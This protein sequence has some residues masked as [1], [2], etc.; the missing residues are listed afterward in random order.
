MKEPRQETKSWTLSSW[1]K[2]LKRWEKE[3]QCVTSPESLSI[4]TWTRYQGPPG[5]MG[6]G[7]GGSLPIVE[8]TEFQTLR[9]L[10][11]GEAEAHHL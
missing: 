2:I 3:R 7:E 1:E 6:G 5:H 8:T 4:E 10:K 9:G 11:E